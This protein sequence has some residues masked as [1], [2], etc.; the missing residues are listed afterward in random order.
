MNYT[1]DKQISF[2]TSIKNVHS[3]ARLP[4]FG[5]DSPTSEGFVSVSKLCGVQEVHSE[6]QH[7]YN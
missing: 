2:I 5:E 3:G 6:Y 1:S 4:G 7:H